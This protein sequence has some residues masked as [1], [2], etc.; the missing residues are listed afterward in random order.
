MQVPPAPGTEPDTGGAPADTAAE[1]AE[2][3]TVEEVLTAMRPP[4]PL[5]PENIEAP[6]EPA[7]KAEMEPEL[8]PEPVQELTS[9]PVTE[10]AAAPEPEPTPAEPQK[11]DTS[12]FKVQLAALR[13]E[14]GAMKEWT[15]LKKRHSD[16]LGSLE[17]S[18]MRADLGANK[19]VFFRLRAGPLAGEAAAK[20][21]CEQLSERKVGCLVVRPEG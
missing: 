20:K 10:P 16:L 7:P 18:V 11:A 3:P 14:D 17:P 4:E 13:E 8:K 15:R 12:G 19:G 6:S 21:L 2:A 5:D 9:A 1:Q